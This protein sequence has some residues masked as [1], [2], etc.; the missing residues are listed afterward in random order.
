[1][2]II[3]DII[4]LLSSGESNLSGALLKTKVLL[5]KLGEKKLLEWVNGE[6]Q[7]YPNKDLLPEYRILRLTVQGNISNGFCRATN[8]IL[9]T[10][11]LEDDLRDKIE[12][13]YMTKSIAVVEEYSRGS[14]IKMTIAPEMYS[15][16]ANGLADKFY[17]ESAWGCYS[18]GAMTQIITE[19]TSRLLGFMLDVS[20]NF[21]EELD[22]Q[23]MKTRSKEV[24]VSELFNNAV[25]GDNTTIVVGNSNSQNINNV[26]SKKDLE[27]LK[28]L[29]RENGVS[30]KDIN[31]LNDAIVLDK[32]CE[33]HKIRNFGSNVSTWVKKM[34]SKTGTTAWDINVGVAGSL[35]ASSISKFYGFLK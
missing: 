29:L 21:T 30:T 23:S 24:G 15:Y 18:A 16:I 28:S 20:E 31:E 26:V 6:L 33:E 14:D 35:L 2:K 5:H 32:D 10:L 22:S 4:E 11:H 27:S 19:V 34:I 25:F 17:V 8:H 9:P 1:M 7:G 12:T 13:A 3:E